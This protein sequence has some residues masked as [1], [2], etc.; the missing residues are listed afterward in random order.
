MRLLLF[1]YLL[2]ATALFAQDDPLPKITLFSNV[3]V[4]DGV[5]DQLHNWDILVQDDKIVQISEEPLMVIQTA[6][7]SI[8][9]GKDWVLMSPFNLPQILDQ[10]DSESCISLDKLNEFDE[11]VDGQRCIEPGAQADLL[12]IDCGALDNSWQ[13]GCWAFIESIQSA[14]DLIPHL[15]LLMIDGE[16]C[17]KNLD[18]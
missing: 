1:C 10:I 4:Y 7:V 15:R 11:F 12:L 13:T 17:Y 2:G 8:I 6:N 3:L 14:Q 16:I 18:Q 5:S 9:S